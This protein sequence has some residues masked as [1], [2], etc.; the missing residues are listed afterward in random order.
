MMLGR[1]DGFDQD[2][3]KSKRDEGAV[4]LGRLLASK[5][6]ALEAL[7]RGARI[8]I[9]AEVEKHLEVAAAAGFTTS[10]MKGNWQPTENRSSSEILVEKPSR[11]RPSA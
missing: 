8:D 7:E 2:K 10:E 11:E 6:D 9:G 1:V 3:A 5:R 4:I